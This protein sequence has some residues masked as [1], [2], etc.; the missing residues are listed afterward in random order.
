MARSLLAEGRATD[1]ARM[2]EPL[3]APLPDAAHAAD[4]GQVHVRCLL[5]R[6]RLLRSGDATGA[7]TLLAP[8]EPWEVRNHL[9]ASQRAEVSLW[10]GWTRA[11]QNATTFDDARALNLLDEAQRI[12]KD[13]LDTDGR[14]WTLLGQAQAY[15][16]I[17]EYSLMLRALE[18]AAPLQEK[19]DDAEAALWLHDRSALGERFRGRYARAQDHIDALRAAADACDDPFA[20]GRADAYQASLDLLLGRSPDDVVETATTAI[21][22]L[23][24]TAEHP[25][26]ALLAA[27]RDRIKALHRRGDWDEADRLITEGLDQ[28]ESLPTARGHLLLERAR[29]ALHRGQ[30]EEV[31]RL[32]HDVERQTD[33]LQHRLL[34]SRVAL[35]RSEHAVRQRRSSDAQHHAERALQRAQETGHRGQQLR[36]LLQCATVRVHRHDLDAARQRLAETDAYSDYFSILPFAARRFRTCAL[37]AEAD[38][39]QHDAR[40]YWT[41]SLSAWSL[42]GD[43]YR[44]AQV[45]LA[46]ARLD[47][48]RDPVQARTL[49]ESAT[50]TFNRLQARTELAEAQTLLDVWPP[51]ANVTPRTQETTIGAS[52]ARAAVSVDLVAEAWLQAAEQLLPDRWLAVYRRD[53]EGIWTRVHEHGAPPDAIHF[54]SGVRWKEHVDG[55]EWVRLHPDAP[56]FYFGVARPQRR[57][58]AWEVALNRMRPWLPVASLAFDHALLRRQMPEATSGEVADRPPSSLPLEEFV[59]A[60]P[61]MHDVVQRV[62]RIRSS[63]SPVLITGERGTGKGEIAR[64]IH[65]TSTRKDAPFQRFTCANVPPDLITCELFGC[66][67]S[68]DP[69]TLKHDGTLAKADGGTV[70][71]DEVAD[72]PLNVQKKLLSVIRTGDAYP[73]DAVHPQ[74]LNVR[75]VASTRQDLEALIRDGQ[76]DEELYYRL[77]TITLHVPPL[78]ERR[79]EIP[80]LARHFLDRL[81]PDGM[82]RPTLTNQAMQALL[83]YDWPGNVRQ[84]R[85]EI[86]RALVFVG[87]EPAPII[88]RSDFSEA[89][90]ESHARQHDGSV[91]VDER[92]LSPEVDLNDVLAGTEKTLIERVLAEHDGHVTAS[93]EALG[94]S[95]QGLYK[96]MKRL[97]IDPSAFQRDTSTAATTS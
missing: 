93:A 87:N 68:N 20:L 54:P 33:R 29:L 86:E 35:L 78:R 12:F 90:A 88:D 55:V 36:A 56:A 70:F 47:R 40:S 85:N 25:C 74:A 38:G 5:A 34:A 71:L 4:A 28:L 91:Q 51:D 2:L 59:Y 92:I 50:L 30:L 13:T 66:V 80:L 77:H 94:L 61:A 8:F 57:D 10:L 58:P 17:D 6:V 75:L 41:Q 83:H 1:V 46:L 73:V 24:R 76:F 31:D 44:T 52:L 3:L 53:A 82:P 95:R 19:G 67:E 84:L 63:H 64:A 23:T 42:S 89:I 14:C 96:K 49:L 97:G 37:L 11:W 60:S 62:L 65:A 16:T 15:L 18:G 48:D 45:Q 22:R 27:T 26:Y 81:R 39:F 32:A 79:E 72:L 21:A 9:D 7:M 69:A 43:V